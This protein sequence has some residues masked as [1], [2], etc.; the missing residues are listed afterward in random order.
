MIFEKK[1][2]D[3]YNQLNKIKKKTKKKLI[4]SI[5]NTTKIDS[6]DYYFTPSRIFKNTIIFGIVVFNDAFA[7]LGTHLLDGKV[8][9]IMVDAEKKIL[10]KSDEI[11]GN[12]ERR[13][14]ENIKTSKMLIYKGNDLTVDSIDLFLTYYFNDDIRGLG[15]KKITI[16]GAGNIGSKLA[17]IL[18]ERGS[19]IVICR[20]DFKKSSLIAKTINLI[21][22]QNTVE[23]VIASRNI[24]NACKNTDIL[25]GA[26]NGKPAINAK[27]INSIKNTA[28]VIDAGKGTLQD[29]A[30]ELAQRRNIKIFRTDVTAALN[31]LIDKSLEME[32]MMEKNFNIKKEKNYTLVSQGLLGSKN[33]IIVDDVNNPKRIYGVCNGKGDF[34]RK[35]DKKQSQIISILK[36][37]YN[38]KI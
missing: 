6:E 13:V 3:L 18:L 36:K 1:I 26:T 35:L 22:P 21:K 19:K 15:G 4:F 17:L 25:I 2:L 28:I 16:V 30:V 38:L 24:E 8:D 5:G 23:K 10:P 33:D 27:M 11:P 31:G 34:Y 29:K 12:I 14:R 7:K 37:K 9:Y 20:R 32:K